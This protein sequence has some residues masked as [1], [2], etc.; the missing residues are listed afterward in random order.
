MS[1]GELVDPSFGTAPAAELPPAPPARGSQPSASVL[2]GGGE[3]QARAY[4]PPTALPSLGPQEGDTS[5]KVAIASDVDPRRMPT[6]KKPSAKAGE[7]P[8][9]LDGDA[10]RP[11]PSGISEDDEAEGEAGSKARGRSAK[12]PML[13]WAVAVTLAVVVGA[14][15]AYWVR[16]GMAPKGEP[17]AKTA[18]AR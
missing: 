12:S 13:I 2:V 7:R 11:A 14:G 17:P 5:S 6:V 4:V 16:K 9:P 3:K 10:A 15:A 8:A 18:P 1:D